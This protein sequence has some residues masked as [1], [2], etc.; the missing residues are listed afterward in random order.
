MLLNNQSFKNRLWKYLALIP[1]VTIAFYFV[2]CNSSSKD[3]DAAP[4]DKILK[5]EKLDGEPI[6]MVVDELPVFPGGEEA[7]MEYLQDNI[8]YPEALRA[9]S[10]TGTVYVSFIIDKSGDVRNPQIMRGV[11][12]DLDAITIEAVQNMPDWTPGKY[13]GEPV[14]MKFNMP[15]KFSLN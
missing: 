11:H 5:G 7:R 9:D 8:T 13:N 3:E 12:E 2:S 4:P 10:V 1:M 15:V 14:N 6:F